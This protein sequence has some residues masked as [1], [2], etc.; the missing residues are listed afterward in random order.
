MI[1]LLH[2]IDITTLS[3]VALHDQ[4]YLYLFL[5]CLMYPGISIRVVSK[6]IFSSRLLMMIEDVS[7]EWQEQTIWCCSPMSVM[8]TNEVWSAPAV[9]NTLD[10]HI[11]HHK[12]LCSTF[13]ALVT[14]TPL[15]ATLAAFFL[16]NCNFLMRIFFVPH[17][18]S[19]MLTFTL[20]RLKNQQFLAEQAV[21]TNLKCPTLHIISSHQ[22]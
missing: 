7:P 14:I 3:L 8:T 16:I 22:S 17:F 13:T 5:I 10:Y 11:T 12:L 9:V 1:N 4:C 2:C 6:M 19:I 15:L 20:N 18:T 21:R